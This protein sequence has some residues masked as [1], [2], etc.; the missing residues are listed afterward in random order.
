[1]HA[2]QACQAPCF[3]LEVALDLLII[4]PPF[5][6]L[7]QRKEYSLLVFLRLFLLLLLLLYVSFSS[8]SPS[9]PYH[10]AFPAALAPMAPNGTLV[11][12]YFCMERHRFTTIVYRFGSAFLHA[13]DWAHQLRR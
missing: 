2:Q 1:M 6:T 12:I 4:V 5:L 3:L 11:R 8:C 13:K 7:Q 10:T 9:L